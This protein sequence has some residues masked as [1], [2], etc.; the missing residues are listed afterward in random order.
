MLALFDAETLRPIGRPF[1]VSDFLFTPYFTP[2]GRR[3]TGNGLFGAVLWDV[4][5]DS[6]QEK[7]CLAAGRNLTRAE[8]RE[9]LGDEPYRRT[10]PDWPAGD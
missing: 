1:T 2:D 9:Y 3:V 7:A 8:W 10:C 4:D 6:W 5:P